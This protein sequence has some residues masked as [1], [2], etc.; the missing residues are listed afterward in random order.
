MD[1]LFGMKIK[2]MTDYETQTAKYG[3]CGK[4]GAETKLVVGKDDGIVMKVE[5]CR[6]CGSMFIVDSNTEPS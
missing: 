4:C 2:M 6:G 1:S 5:Y 3:M